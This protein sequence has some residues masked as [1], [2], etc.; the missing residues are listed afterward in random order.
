MWLLSTDGVIDGF[1]ALLST[2]LRRGYSQ[3][4]IHR[5]RHQRQKSGTRMR[6]KQEKVAQARVEREKKKKTGTGGLSMDKKGGLFSDAKAGKDT[7]QKV[8]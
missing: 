7:T 5:K 3:G 6:L 4:L 2:A 8:I 1:Q